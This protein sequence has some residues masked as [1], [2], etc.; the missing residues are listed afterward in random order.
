MS[1][2]VTGSE[3]VALARAPRWCVML[4]MAVIIGCQSRECYIVHDAQLVAERQ[5]QGVARLLG[6]H[7]LAAGTGTVIAIREFEYRDVRHTDNQVFRK[8]SIGLQ[9][10]DKTNDLR[11]PGVEVR[12]SRAN[13]AFVSRGTG[14]YGTDAQGHVSRVPR[15]SGETVTV[16]GSVAVVNVSSR[17]PSGSVRLTDVYECYAL[18]LSEVSPWIGRQSGDLAEEA[19]PVTNVIGLLRFLTRRNV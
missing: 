11:S 15:G 16:D 17:S 10:N 14:E 1:R 18:S 3:R 7:H 6:A 2:T 5:E 12:Y 9:N 4:M 13:A 19:S 8:L